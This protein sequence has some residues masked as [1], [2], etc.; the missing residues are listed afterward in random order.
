MR[1]L[2]NVIVAFCSLPLSVQAAGLD[3][4]TDPVSSGA[5]SEWQVSAAAQVQSGSSE[6]VETSIAQC[7]AAAVPACLTRIQDY[8]T[9]YDIAEDNVGIDQDPHKQPPAELLA[10]DAIGLQYVFPADIEAIAAAKGWPAVRYKSRHAGGFDSETPSLLMVY[11][12]GD[13]VSPPVTYD[14]WLNF[15]IPAD[16]GDQELTPVPQ[17]PVPTRENYAAELTGGPGLPHTF[18]MV[19]L[20]RRT[21]SQPGQIFFQKFY[22]GETG[23]PNFTPEGNSS[24][25]GCYSCHPN[26]L[27]AISPLGYHVRAGET[28]MPEKEWKTVQVINDAMDSAAGFATV[29]WRDVV[30]DA[31]AGTRKPLLRPK[32]YGPII[33]ATTPL[34]SVGRTQDF[35][36]GGNGQTGCYNTR[37]TVDVTDIFGRPPGANNIYTLTAAPSIR[38]EKVRDAMNCEKCHNNS[39]RGAFNNQT[40]F[41]QLDFKI[42]VDQSMPFGSHTNPLDDD[43]AATD[44]VQDKLTGDERIALANCLQAEFSL[45]QQAVPKWLTA[46]SCE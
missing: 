43:G 30:T 32:S 23:H 16:T 40:N 8:G 15:A 35:I 44:P 2:K 42:L 18:T 26:G 4:L 41:A 46:V 25:S 28:Q 6:S 39:G 37:T 19:T 3:C 21:D 1:Y 45:E 11:V 17:A 38:W 13:K 33:G 5:L 20:E 10:P 9:R 14:R 29:S 36:M 34:N 12:P 24:V 27:R 31:T 22:R 7:F